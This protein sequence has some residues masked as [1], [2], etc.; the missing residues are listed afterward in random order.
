[1]QSLMLLLMAISAAASL[2]SATIKHPVFPVTGN[3]DTLQKMVADLMAMGEAEML[4]LVPDRNGMLFCGCPNCKGGTQ[5]SQMAW[6]GPSDPNR[7]HCQFCDM[8]FPNEQY[9][10]NQSIDV[11]NRAG[12]KETWRYHGNGKPEDQY[13][14]EARARYFAKEYMAARLLD[15]ARLYALSGDGN[16]GRRAV[17]LLRRFAEVF[18]RWCVV[19]DYPA[20]GKKYPVSAA[21][22]PYPYWAGIWNRWHLYDTPTP[23]ALAY[24]L[25]YHLLDHET[26][27]RVENDLLRADVA[28]QRTYD[29]VTGES[30]P[31]DQVAP[32]RSAGFILIGRVINEPDFIHDGVQRIRALCAQ[33]FHFDGMHRMG[34]PSY[35]IQMVN[36]CRVAADYAHGYS[37]PPGYTSPRDGRRFADLDLAGEITSLGM[38]DLATQKMTLPN[39]LVVPVHDAWA[40]QKSYN[41]S[42]PALGAML[43]N[44]Y[45][46]GRL[47]FGAADHT[48]QAHLHFSGGDAHLHYDNLSLTL[49]AHGREWLSDIGYTHTPWR[50]WSTQS[51]SHNTVVVDGKLHHTEALGGDLRLFDETANVQ[52]IDVSQ[53]RTYPDVTEAF[54]RRLILVRVDSTR[55]YVVD[56]FTVR[57]GKQHDYFLHGSCDTPQSAEI[58]M[59]LKPV[60]GTL[61][62]PDAAYR[63]PAHESDRGEAPEGQLLAY[64]MF[65]DLRDA[66]TDQPFRIDWRFDDDSPP[67]MRTHVMGQ[68]GCR[69]ISARTPQIRPVQNWLHG[70]DQT[71]LDRYWKPSV[72]V[73]REGTA[74]LS[75]AFVV[76]HEAYAAEPFITSVTGSLTIEHTAGADT[77]SSN[78]RGVSV[79]RTQDGRERF[80]YELEEGVAGRVIGAQDGALLIDAG[81]CAES[82]VAGRTMVVTH[83]DG[84][85]HGYRIASIEPHRDHTLVRVDGQLGFVIEGD[86]TRFTSF[87]LREVKG[88]NTVRI[89]DVRYVAHE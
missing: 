14:F 4:A 71:Q 18:P 3:Y 31:Y 25:V 21:A 79:V 10:L 76:V 20:P 9:P 46:H 49:W 26:R 5:D 88:A 8:V 61:L 40:A 62:G 19:H 75:S 34:T 24:D 36:N 47:S 43:L 7:V 82:Q 84:S 41:L 13:Y 17:V 55:A 60:S 77:V 44:S 11:I 51:P 50:F 32:Q 56:I 86:T 64:A 28:Y 12:E 80:R 58:D 6:N 85:T 69:V 45:G 68:P 73:R 53:P 54:R 1:M 42:A 63:L 74:P 59:P 81:L 78:D 57:G 16:H 67:R 23:V 89:H 35:H 39:G 70:E 27:R 30:Q 65:R 29:G 48:T 33:D 72:V 22:A 66:T 2:P 83:G 37:D 52:V 87:P 15:L 38:A